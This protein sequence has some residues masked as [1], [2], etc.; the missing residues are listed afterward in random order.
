MKKMI[1]VFLLILPVFMGCNDDAVTMSAIRDGEQLEEGT[2]IKLD[3][4]QNSPN[5]FN[6]STYIQFTVYEKMNVKLTV[7]TED[8]MRVKE[9]V[10]REYEP[11]YY[12]IEF[13]SRNAEG[14]WLPS[15]N[16]YYTL[17]GN[18]LILTR[19]MKLLK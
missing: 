12:K 10:N 16:Y 13:D 3:L 14:D 7:Y 17:E 6:P 15:G 4:D 2:L 1:S 19:Q 18:G 9:I 8:W 11:G 5:P